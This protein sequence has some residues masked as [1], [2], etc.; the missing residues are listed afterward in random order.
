MLALSQPNA[1]RLELSGC[2]DKSHITLTEPLVDVRIAAWLLK[3]DAVEVTDSLQRVPMKKGGTPWNL[4]GLLIRATSKEASNDAMTAL[5]KVS[6]ET[7][8]H[9]FADVC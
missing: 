8:G 7:S 9:L 3:P 1:Y 4:E 2:A 6:G 5:H